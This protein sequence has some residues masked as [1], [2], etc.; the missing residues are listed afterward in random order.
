MSRLIPKHKKGKK[1]FFKQQGGTLAQQ[2]AVENQRHSTLAKHYVQHPTLP[3]LAKA[4]YHWFKSKPGLGGQP[5]TDYIYQT[6]IA[7]A[8]G[9]KGVISPEAIKKAE[10]IATATKFV[11]PSANVTKTIKNAEALE[12][13]AK[14][15]VK[16]LTK[17]NLISNLE[18]QNLRQYEAFETPFNKIAR[19]LYMTDD[20]AKS[21]EYLKQ[22]ENLI[23]RF[24]NGL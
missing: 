20:P 24:K 23:T 3:N 9:L 8:V 7:P 18:I 11:G 22:I 16:R 14:G 21:S 4:G 1:I 19:K 5:E 15:A 6:G 12:K 13:G 10:A 2:R 17:K